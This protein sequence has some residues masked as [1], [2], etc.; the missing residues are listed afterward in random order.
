MM[1]E[2]FLPTCISSLPL[3]SHATPISYT[4]SLLSSLRS[5]LSPF[6]SV[7]Y[8]STIINP[9]FPPSPICPSHYSTDV[10]PKIDDVDCRRQAGI[11]DEGR[12]L[13]I[14]GCR[15]ELSVYGC[16]KYEAGGNGR[17]GSDVST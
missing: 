13:V 2:S 6:P 5:L 17:R 11:R 14:M 4:F 9:S 8:H 7:S 16:E 12:R 15:R 1:G 3:V 10:E